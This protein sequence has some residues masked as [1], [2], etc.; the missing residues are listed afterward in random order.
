MTTAKPASMRTFYLVWFGQMISLIGSSLTSFGLGVWVFQ[1][2]G[3][4]TQFA[5]IAVAAI[6]PGILISPI[7]GALIDRYDRRKVMMFADLAAGLSTVAVA[8]L[9]FSGRLEIWHIY[10]TS[11]LSSTASAFQG[12]AYSAAISQLVPKARLERASGMVSASQ[13]IS[14]ILGPALAGALIGLIGLPGIITIDF[15]TFLFAVGTLLFVRFPAYQRSTTHESRPSLWQDARYGWKYMLDRPGLFALVVFFS[16]INFTWALLDPLLTP[17]V[18]SFADPSAL[19]FVV[20]AMGVGMM[21]GSLLMATWGGPKR[22]MIMIYGFAILQGTLQM[23]I[24]S[25]ESIPLL[26]G[27]HLALLIGSPLVNG[28]IQVLL[29]RK[30]PQD[31]QGRVFAAGRMLAMAAIPVAYLLSGPLADNVFRPLLRENGALAGSIGHIIGVGDGRGIGLMYI[32]AGLLTLVGTGA[33][34]LYG[35]MRRIERELP[36]VTPDDPPPPDAGAEAEP[37]LTADAG[38]LATG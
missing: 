4:A 10:I 3:S 30:V 36:D 21:V 11:M 29:Q 2:T 14:M 28:S 26:A 15:A 32:L 1:R 18:L 19:G 17:M 23:V 37:A 8:L 24:G 35:P 12:P 25:R 6:L 31:V 7:A 38:A 13:G 9:L 5:L 27:A 34:L 22:K 16:F 20:S 33:A